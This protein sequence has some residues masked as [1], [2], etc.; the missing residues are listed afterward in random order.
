MDN[1]KENAMK[2][3]FGNFYSEKLLK[4]SASKMLPDYLRVYVTESGT[5]YTQHWILY[6]E[7][8]PNSLKKCIKRHGAE[9]KNI[10]A[11][12][13]LCPECTKKLKFLCVL[14]SPAVGLF[15]AAVF[16]AET[17]EVVVFN[18]H[19]ISYLWK[20]ISKFRMECDA[21]KPTSH[22]VIIYSGTTRA[23]LIMP[24]IINTPFTFCNLD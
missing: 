16:Q 4:A 23:G 22:P 21:E 12:K 17:N 18:A 24:C 19:Y 11:A 9:H 14:L 7:F 2:K 1:V 8:V 5:V 15:H 20:H 6:K 13:I 10:L 3:F